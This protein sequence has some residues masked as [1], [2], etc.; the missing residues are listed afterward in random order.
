VLM[1]DTLLANFTPDEIEVIF[2]HE[3]GH[4]VFRHIRKMIASGAIYTAAGF[5]LVD[6]LVMAWVHSADPAADYANF[7]V[8][9]LPLIMLVLTLFSLLLEPLQNAISR[10]FERQCDRYALERT[11]QPVAYI[12]AFQKLAR[13]NKDDPSPHWLEVFWFHSHPPIRERLAVAEKR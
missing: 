13:L 12:S 5:V 6:R 3:I 8:N 1:G 11:G 2:A 7:P 10:H 9:T 4:H